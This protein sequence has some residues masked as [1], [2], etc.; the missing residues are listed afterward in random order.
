MLVKPLDWC[1]WVFFEFLPPP[2]IKLTPQNVCYKSYIHV[3]KSQTVGELF[4]FQSMNA[5]VILLSWL[6]YLWIDGWLELKDV[7]IYIQ[8]IMLTRS[9]PVYSFFKNKTIQVHL[10]KT[11][12]SFLIHY[13]YHILMSYKTISIINYVYFT[14]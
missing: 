9:L 5:P 14:L 1:S 3:V 10:D 11:Y 4:W 13:Q 7:L 6:T 2:Q 8:E 12:L